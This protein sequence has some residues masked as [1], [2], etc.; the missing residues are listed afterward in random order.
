MYLLLHVPPFYQVG[1]TSTQEVGDTCSN[2]CTPGRLR[3]GTRNK[4]KLSRDPPSASPPRVRF[5]SVVIPGLHGFFFFFLLRFL[6]FGFRFYWRVGRKVMV[7][8]V[9]NYCLQ[10]FYRRAYRMQQE[11]L[12]RVLKRKR[13]EAL[14]RVSGKRQ[15]RRQAQPSSWC[16]DGKGSSR[17]IIPCLHRHLMYRS[18]FHSG[19]PTCMYRG[20]QLATIY[21]CLSNTHYLVQSTVAS[22]VVQQYPGNN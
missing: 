8:A 12:D 6:V 14:R 9:I 7:M 2:Y 20:I 16:Q 13:E 10:L 17:E 19:I 11:R 4:G 18:T 21:K 3:K 15:W 22:V 1:G 5:C